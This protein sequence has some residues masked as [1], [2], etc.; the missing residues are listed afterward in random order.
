MPY[1]VRVSVWN[2]SASTCLA[3][4][5]SADFNGGK[6]TYDDVN[7][8]AELVLGLLYEQVAGGSG[9]RNYYGGMNIVEVSAGDDALAQAVTTN[10]APNTDSLTGWS[11]N[12]PV[13]V[14]TGGPGGAKDFE[15][16][17]TGSPAS[18]A[19][20]NTGSITV[21]PGTL[22]Q[23]SMYVDPS[24]I[25]AGSFALQ[26][27][28][29]TLGVTQYKSQAFA[30]RTP[31]RFSFTTAWTCPVGVTAIAL[32]VNVNGCTVAS[33][34][35]LKFSQPMWEAKSAA[36]VWYV[37]SGTSTRLYCGSTLPYDP[38]QGA[39]GQ[40]LYLTDA[41]IGGSVG[42]TMGLSMT[43]VGTDAASS[44]PY[45]TVNSTPLTMPGNPGSIGAY[46][47]GTTLGRR[48]YAGIIRKVDRPNQKQPKATITLGPLSSAFD[49]A[50]WGYTVGA[51]ANV[52][53][54]AVISQILLNAAS[55]WPHLTISAA[56]FAANTGVTF[57]GQ[58]QTGSVAQDIADAQQAI[59][60]G[61]SWLLRVGHDRTPRFIRLYTSG[62]NSYTYP[63]TLTQGT[64][65]FE[66]LNVDDVDNDY[67]TFYNRVL[68]TGAQN[69]ATQQPYSAIVSD[70]ASIA[71]I[72]R[73]VDA[74][75][76]SNSAL[77]S[78]TACAQYG[79]ALL[80]QYSIG[81][82]RSSF[83]VYTIDNGTHD[84][85]PLGLNNGDVV[86]AV[87]CVTVA[88]YQSGAPNKFGLPSACVTVLDIANCAR[89]QE[90]TYGPIEPDWMSA[91]IQRDNA[92]ATAI[93]TGSPAGGAGQYTVQPFAAPTWSGSSLALAMPA[94]T[95]MFS[96]PTLLS[97]TAQ[98]VTLTASSTNW[99][100]LTSGG[101]YDVQTSPATRAGEVL[102][103][104]AMTNAT[105]ILGFTPLVATSQ[106]LYPVSDPFVGQ[107]SNVPAAGVNVNPSYTSSS[108]TLQLSVPSYTFTR[109]N[110]TATGQTWVTPAASSTN[111]TGLSPSTT[112]HFNIWYVIATNT[113]VF[114]KYSTTALTPAQ[115][116]EAIQDGLVPIYIDFPATTTASGT[117]S[118]GGGNGGAQ[119]PAVH[120][121]IE[122]RERGFVRA[123][124]LAIGEHLRDP[125]DGW[126][127]IIRVSVLPTTLYRIVTRDESVDVNASHAVLADDGWW[128]AVT[129]LRPGTRL[130]ALCGEEP[131]VVLAVECLGPGEYVPIECER[132]RY[133]LGRHIG[134]NITY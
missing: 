88:G 51:A 133:V 90:V 49:E 79:R 43:G 115:R 11:T 116:A 13:S 14:G 126:N 39:D 73:V 35:K 70:N 78:T 106:L 86:R 91:V 72:G 68:V 6:I 122:T 124:S 83:A 41:A 66:P 47:A 56:N 61:D 27:Y 84:V 108:T 7:G 129:E 75:P 53:V 118:G 46:A 62:T 125:L 105:G 2:P 30:S 4:D 96:P 121:L 94:L 102:I 89:W 60:T 95:A 100:W 48:V 127:A 130:R 97:I 10:L 34:Q 113:V 117:G 109:S 119:C 26:I 24:Q 99:L 110:S 9:A 33:G 1:D 85:A 131:P 59:N 65:A 31:G 114:T 52:D 128:T 69:P 93:Q 12:G 3:R 36:S 101:A 71:L 111:Y 54:T 38:A 57:V 92:V 19:W 82:A 40:L 123:D 112:Y 55:Q 77:N 16:T 23:F 64:T 67:T 25:A 21:V 17:G 8:S 98:N 32:L 45:L 76:V 50:Q 15:Y 29:P 22:Y 37:P 87:N 120:Q 81:T 28:D 42:L 44:K 58:R 132:N 103:G 134:H 104:F 80:N 18:T 5:A 20:A 63:L 107:G 74:Q